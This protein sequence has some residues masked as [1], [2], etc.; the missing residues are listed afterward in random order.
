MRSRLAREFRAERIESLAG[1]GLHEVFGAPARHKRGTVALANDPL[2]P[3]RSLAEGSLEDAC[4]LAHKSQ[5]ASGLGRAG[6]DHPT[7]FAFG[8]ELTNP[9]PPSHRSA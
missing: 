6:E 7:T 4:M 3:R 5:E 2:D 9:L 1:G 8:N